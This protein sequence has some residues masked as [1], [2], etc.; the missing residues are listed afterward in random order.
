MPTPHLPFVA[1]EMSAY[2]PKAHQR[3]ILKFTPGL[4]P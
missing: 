2:G 4:G 3:V 1:G